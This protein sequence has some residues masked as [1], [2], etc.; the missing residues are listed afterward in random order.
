MKALGELATGS[1]FLLLW[2]MGVVAA[3][4]WL[5]ALA[6]I[7]PPYAWYLAVELLMRAAG[8]I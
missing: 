8:L 5:K 7:L 1:L 6:V 4:G 3:S 2:I